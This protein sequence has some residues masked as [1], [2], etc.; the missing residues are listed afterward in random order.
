VPFDTI[1]ATSCNEAFKSN[2]KTYTCKT[3]ISSVDLK[4][5]CNRAIH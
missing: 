2:R 3:A 4:F 5:I 1:P